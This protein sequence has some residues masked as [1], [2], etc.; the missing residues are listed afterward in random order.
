MERGI[1]KFIDGEIYYYYDYVADTIELQYIDE[2]DT[3]YPNG[4]NKR[5][6][7]R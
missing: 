6:V 1:I 4:Y 5:R 7:H 3:W 2:Y